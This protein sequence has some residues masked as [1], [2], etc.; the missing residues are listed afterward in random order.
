[1]A[2]LKILSRHDIVYITNGSIIADPLEAEHKF[3]ISHPR[4]PAIA[5]T[6]DEATDPLSLLQ[7]VVGAI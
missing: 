3:T 6:K 5:V 7:A 1:M 2:K 4:L